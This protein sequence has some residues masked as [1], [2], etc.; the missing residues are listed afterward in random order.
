MNTLSIDNIESLIG[1]VI[2]WRA[3]GYAAKILTV[4]PKSLA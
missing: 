1:K 4:Y 3:K 2:K